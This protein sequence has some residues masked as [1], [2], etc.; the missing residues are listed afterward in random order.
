MKMHYMLMF[1]FSLRRYVVT[2]RKIFLIYSQVLIGFIED[3]GTLSTLQLAY[4]TVNF[5]ASD[6]DVG[7]GRDICKQELNVS[8]TRKGFALRRFQETSIMRH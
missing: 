7:K 1:V 3:Q 8:I 4:M 6:L 5:N 2:F